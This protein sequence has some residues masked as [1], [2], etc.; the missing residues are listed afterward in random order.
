MSCLV[1]DKGIQ[2]MRDQVENGGSEIYKSDVSA[3]IDSSVEKT[4]ERDG[5]LLIY[6]ERDHCFSDAKLDRSGR[7][8]TVTTC[9]W[10]DDPQKCGE[11]LANLSDRLFGK[12]QESYPTSLYPV[13]VWR[14][15]SGN[16]LWLEVHDR[17]VKTQFKTALFFSKDN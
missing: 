1:V 17:F 8:L 9:W 15:P 3:Y 5:E 10:V 2:L 14:D 16:A 7:V 11:F 12:T 4:K 13:Y 6:N